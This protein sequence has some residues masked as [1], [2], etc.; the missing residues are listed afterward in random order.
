M[1]PQQHAE[2]LVASF[3]AGAVFAY[4]TEAVYGLGCDPDNESA[5]MDLLRLKQR[6]VEKGLILVARSYSQ[7]LPYV[8]DHKIPMDFRTE[9]FSSWPGPN[10]WLL[11]ASKAA[12]RWITGGSDVIAVRV[13]NH[14]VVAA[15]CELFDKPLVSTSANLTGQPS[16]MSAAEVTEQFDQ[17]VIV[18]DGS[19]GKQAKPSKI[20]HGLTG[21]VIRDN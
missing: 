20:R 6:P 4:P 7:L 12:P 15:L 21:K 5:V 10:T 17:Q 2:T 14:P 8:D 11:P 19:L 3:S 1:N 13:P 18:I 16:A 9:I